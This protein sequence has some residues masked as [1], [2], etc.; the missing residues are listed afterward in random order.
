M[1][2]KVTRKS[3]KT[4]MNVVNCKIYHWKSHQKRWRKRWITENLTGKVT[5]KGEGKGES[6]KISPKKSKKNLGSYMISSITWLLVSCLSIALSQVRYGW[7]NAKSHPNRWVGSMRPER[8]WSTSAWSLAATSPQVGKILVWNMILLLIIQ[9]QQKINFVTFCTSEAALTKLSYVLGKESW[10]LDERRWLLNV[11][12]FQR[13]RQSGEMLLIPRRAMNLSLR[14]EMTVQFE[15]INPRT[16]ELNFNKVGIR[17]PDWSINLRAHVEPDH[18][19][20]VLRS[21]SWPWWRRWWRPCTSLARR[22]WKV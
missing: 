13:Q 7:L 21:T 14:G 18:N 3:P 16:Q 17:R 22:R 11:L 5:K 6:P 12:I 1:T 19:H 20:L 9:R 4:V 15:A 10:G 8:L 2:K